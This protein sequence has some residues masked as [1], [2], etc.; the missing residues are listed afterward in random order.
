MSCFFFVQF[1]IETIWANVVSKTC[2]WVG[3]VEGKDTIVV[4]KVII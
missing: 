2:V 1:A 4:E 3:D